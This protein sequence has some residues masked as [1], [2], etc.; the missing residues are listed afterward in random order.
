MEKRNPDGNWE[1]GVTCI[2][3]TE[4]DKFGIAD[5]SLVPKRY[6]IFMYLFYFNISS[7][8]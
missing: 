7:I 2:E 4:F 3:Y 5:G 1:Y 8:S 6:L